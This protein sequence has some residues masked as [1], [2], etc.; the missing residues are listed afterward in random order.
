VAGFQDIQG[1]WPAHIAQSDKSDAHEAP[2]VSMTV[3]ET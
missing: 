1:H 3:A 2:P